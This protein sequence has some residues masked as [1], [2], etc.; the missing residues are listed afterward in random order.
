LMVAPFVAGPSYPTLDNTQLGTA[1]GNLPGDYR[2]AQSD[3]LTLQQQQQALEQQKFLADQQKSLAGAFSGG[4]PMDASGQ[5]DYAKILQT[6]AQKGD[7]GAIGQLGPLAQQSQQLSQAAQPSPL[8]N[9]AAV[10]Q[11]GSGDALSQLEAG[12]ARVETGGQKDPYHAIGKATGSGDRAYGKYQV[13]GANIPSWTK[14]VLGREMTKK[15]FLDDPDAQEAVA[16]SKLG[17]YLQQ[18]G[19]APDAASKWFTGKPL[20]Q[21]ANRKDVN[22]MTGA[23][24]AE[25]ATGT[26]NDATP[27][28]PPVSAAA[29][30]SIPRSSGAPAG[31]APS[32]G[33]PQ[34]GGAAGSVASLVSGAVQDP[35][36]AA[37][38]APNI[39]KAVGVSDPTAPLT[40][41]QAQRAQKLLA[42]YAARTGQQSPQSAPQP[43]PSPAGAPAGQQ[44]IIPQVPLPKGFTDP[45]KAILA[46]DQEISRVGANPQAQSQVKAL[47]DW[48][49]RIA[50]STATIESR[51]GESFVDPRTGATL[52]Q[53]QYP[54][55]NLDPKA[56]ENAAEAYVKTG[57]LPTGI[58]RGAQGPQEIAQ[59]LS[60]AAQ[61]AEQRG[62]DPD[63]LAENW[64]SFG[65]RSGGLKTL[66]QRATGLTLVENEANRLI[67][68]VRELLPQLDH[69]QY[70]DLNAAINAYKERTG[71]P[72]IVKLGISAESLS[73]VYARI[74]KGGGTP[75]G[76]ET[77]RA[78]EMLN[79]AWSSGQINAALD[80]MGL[81]LQSAKQSTDDTLKEYGLSTKDIAPGASPPPAPSQPAAGGLPKGWSVKVIP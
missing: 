37:K 26:K 34:Q 45:Q 38:V 75:T 80:Q 5:P 72:S 66:F 14:E 6:L 76:G 71:D 7:I 28:I 35:A 12:I 65:A 56:T 59:I 20:A 33:G 52:F 74:L 64:Q 8:F 79:K 40:P 21:G 44:P 24:Y 13:M 68:R 48:R 42:G 30:S 2:K 41:E 57:K 81:E 46:I 18:Y 11:A 27:S 29:G 39:A 53:G 16:K 43:V 73:S 9:G 54:G 1:L 3:Q 4:V 60:R 22:G 36:L 67:P 23:K 15:E 17:Q 61:I 55:G 50:Q 62:I 51:P 58:G 63:K 69:T 47:A 32:P 77:E 31:Q 19:D 25:L 10:P 70:K 78:H 49:D